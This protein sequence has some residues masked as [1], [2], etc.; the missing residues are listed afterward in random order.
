VKL[1]ENEFSKQRLIEA[2][3]FLS[4]AFVILLNDRAPL[5]LQTWYPSVNFEATFHQYWQDVVTGNLP[6]PFAYRIAIPALYGKIAEWFGPPVLL[7]FD[8]GLKLIFLFLTQILFFNYLE[9]FFSRLVAFSGVGLLCFF[10]T[11]GLSFITGPSVIE[12]I[13][14]LNLLFFVA[15]LHC[16]QQEKFLLACTLA[17]LSMF[18]RET[19]LLLAALPVFHL[20]KKQGWQKSLVLAAAMAI[21][22]IS[23]RVFLPTSSVMGF[24]LLALKLNVPFLSAETTG[25]ALISN[26]HFWGV[27]GPLLLAAWFGRKNLPNFLR[28]ALLIA[29]SFIAVHYVF[30]TI[31]ERRLWLPLFILVMPGVLQ[32]FR[33]QRLRQD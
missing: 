20:G 28:A 15:I 7:S 8:L 33:N 25:R 26:L 11:W 16:L 4:F 2:L 9:K 14:L 1:P 32:F 29:P 27:V 23:L 24:S 3:L 31:I 13:D 10:T 6:G 21:P 17:L 30:G 5:H 19:C 22:Y 18:N 12:T